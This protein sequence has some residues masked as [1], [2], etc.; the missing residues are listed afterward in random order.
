MSRTGTRSSTRGVFT[1]IRALGQTQGRLGLDAHARTWS[2]K[3][4]K[5]GQMLLNRWVPDRD[6]E[7]PAEKQRW[8]RRNL[9]DDDAES[10]RRRPARLSRSPD[11]PDDTP[12][13]PMLDNDNAAGDDDADNDDWHASPDDG[14]VVD[15]EA[16]SNG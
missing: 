13:S 4:Q 5:V 7:E 11:A 8:H 15:T 14:A 6:Q 3:R 9:G 10:V 1:G 16:A 12:R 2:R